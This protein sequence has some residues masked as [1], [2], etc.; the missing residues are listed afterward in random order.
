MLQEWRSDHGSS[1]PS[2][3]RNALGS[4]LGSTE[5]GARPHGIERVRRGQWSPVGDQ[6][7]SPNRSVTWRCPKSRC[8]RREPVEALA[9]VGRA[10]TGGHQQRV[11]EAPLL[12]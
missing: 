10:S 4:Q 12:P 8:W 7:R 2:G 5:N 1:T 9:W 11:P 6:V 3:G